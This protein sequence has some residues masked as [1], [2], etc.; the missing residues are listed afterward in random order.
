M[1]RARVALASEQLSPPFQELL[2]EM[3]LTD[4]PHDSTSSKAG[5]MLARQ[6]I[7]RAFVQGREALSRE[8]AETGPAP[9]GLPRER[10]PDRMWPECS[11]WPW[12]RTTGTVIVSSTGS[13][14]VAGYASIPLA[15][16]SACRPRA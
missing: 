8:F 5:G 3:V 9:P 11:K 4:P 13:E 10:S 6:L 15:R 7:A 16:R 1:T 2:R 14:P 12:E